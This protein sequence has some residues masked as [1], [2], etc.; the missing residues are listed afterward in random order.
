MHAMNFMNGIFCTSSYLCVCLFSPVP[1]F[2][3]NHNYY[4]VCDVFI[5][6]VCFREMCF[7][8]KSLVMFPGR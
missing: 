3:T 1:L 8:E 2:S 6:C 7:R 4:F 5:V